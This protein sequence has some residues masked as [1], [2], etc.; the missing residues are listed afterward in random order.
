MTD[1]FSPPSYLLSDFFYDLPPEL[2]ADYPAFLRTGSRLFCLNKETGIIK[3]KFFK[4]ILDFVNPGDLLI[5]NDTKVIPARLFAHKLSGGKVE[6]L[7]ERILDKNRILAHLKSNKLLK[8]GTQLQ[9]VNN[10]R[11]E[12][13]GRVDNLFELLFLDEVFSVIELLNTIGRIPLPPY[14]QRIDEALDRERYQTIFARNPG[15]VAAP[16]AGLHFDEMLLSQLKA[17]GVNINFITLHVGSGTFQPIR[18]ECINKHLMHAEYA[19]VPLSV[20]DQIKETKKNHKRVIAVGTTT[21]RALETA[22]VNGHIQPFEGETRLFIYPGFSFHCVDALMTNFHL[23]K[24]SL[25]MLVCAFAGYKFT[26]AAYQ[27]AI[28]HKYRFFSYGDAMWIS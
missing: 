14:L 4:D 27:E 15:A 19:I 10:I 17:K 21:V 22:T 7:V 9:L 1:I 13:L 24:S 26:M 11:V 25:L 6:I 2:I 3:H 20:C 18:T 8:L 16:T 5:L 12:I 23:P 28:I